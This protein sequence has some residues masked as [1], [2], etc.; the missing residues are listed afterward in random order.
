MLSLS[1]SKILSNSWFWLAIV[2]VVITVN[3]FWGKSP[4]PPRK[5]AFFEKHK[6]AITRTT[7]IFLILVILFVWVSL[8]YMA[9]STGV[10]HILK[11]T[12]IA[13]NEL[14]ADSVAFFAIGA[15]ALSGKSGILIGFL[16]IFWS[17]LTTRKRLILAVVSVLP[18]GFTILAMLAAR[19]DEP[20]AIWPLVMM[21]LGSL[22]SCWLVNGSA[23]IAGQHFFRV[24][25]LLM[26]KLKLASGEFLQ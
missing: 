6:R 4:P 9:I 23:I 18:I 8:T 21:C 17:N 25:W 7:D 3:Y 14:V 24:A 15:T 16:S 1:I 5:S 26:C 12:H 13:T 19:F 22:V 2:A 10:A 11:R 20:E